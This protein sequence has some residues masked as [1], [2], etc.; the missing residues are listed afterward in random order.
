MKILHLGLEDH[1]RPGSGGGSLRNHEINRRLA[2]D[3]QIEVV[4]AAYPGCRAR[5]EDGVHHRHV[6]CG[7]GYSA[8][9]LSY[10]A[11]LP[12]VVRRAV[13]D[14]KPDLI[15]EE[16][17]PPWSSLAVGRWT[18]VPTLGL[19]Q[20]FFAAEKAAQYHLPA[21]VLTAIERFGTRSHR[22]LIAVSE[23]L[24]GRL[25][26]VAPTSRVAVVGNGVDSVEIADAL[27]T[28][29]RRR[30][31]RPVV[32]FLGRLETHQKGLDLLMEAF[33]HVARASDA[34]L[35]I[36]GDGR[37][38]EAV[39]DMV[40]R[41]GLAARTELLGRVSGA[42]KWRML[43]GCDVLAVPSRYETFGMTALEALACGTPVAAFDIPCLRDTIPVGAGVLA[44]RFDCQAYGDELVGLLTAPG[45]RAAMGELG[46]DY[47]GTQGWDSLA[48]S[49]ATVYEEAASV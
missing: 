19:V 31:P 22:T 41:A 27:R 45:R 5:V 38:R 49:Q 15:V 25:R 21:S 30:D 46:R 8:S 13:R 36:A 20:G 35:V 42:E 29:P 34:R 37:D 24:A 33:A 18:S 47:A 1:R 23:D 12:A 14:S 40:G 48:R 32:G 10:Q 11:A 28:M 2:G 9:L 16:F 17:A 43:A 4:T 3:H 39:R 44:P 26:A 6:G 7:R